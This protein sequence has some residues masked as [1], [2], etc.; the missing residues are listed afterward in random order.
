M[1]KRLWKFLRG[2]VAALAILGLAAF[3]LPRVF[4]T[5]TSLSKTYSVQDAPRERA[6][7]VFGAGLSRTGKP[8]AILRDRIETAVQLYATGKVEKLLMSGGEWGYARSEPE[9]MRDYAMSLGVPEES[10]VLDHAGRRTYD[11]CYRAKTIF[12]LD[13]ALLVTQRFHLP[14]ALFVCNALGLKAEGVPAANRRYWPVM[15]L[16]WNVREQF[17][18]VAAVVDVFLSRPE[19]ILGEPQ[20]VF[21][22]GGPQARQGAARARGDNG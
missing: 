9:A 16:I 4:T 17:A 20:P 11:T 18:T 22:E 3:I 13:S 21:V 6:A 7:I 19:P 2:L 5:L 12:G 15:S 8:T 14:R 1:L 10:I